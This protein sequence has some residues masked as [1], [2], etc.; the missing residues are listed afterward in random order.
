MIQDT[1]TIENILMRFPQTL[2]VF[3]DF[4]I[5]AIACGEPIWGTIGENAKQYNVED[6]E[7]LINALNDASKGNSFF[8]K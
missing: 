1:D 2:T 6:I 4:G 3:Q 5:P 8:V 7:K